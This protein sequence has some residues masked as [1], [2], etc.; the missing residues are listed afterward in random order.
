MI[1]ELGIVYILNTAYSERDV[2]EELY[3]PD[4]KFL[5]ISMDDDSSYDISKDFSRCIEFIKSAQ[6]EQQP[7]LI[8]CMA[9]VSR[10]ATITIAYFMQQ[11]KMSLEEA[12]EY[13]FQKRRIIFPN[14][15]FIKH[16]MEFEKNL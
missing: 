3:G 9:G 12:A 6:V 7:I 5:G 14:I 13:V 2:N 1:Q 8:H 4:R 16:L 15:G 11:K 10:S